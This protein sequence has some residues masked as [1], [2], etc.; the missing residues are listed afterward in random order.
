MKIADRLG[1]VPAI[2][3]CSLA[4]LLA[5]A[6]LP[7]VAQERDDDTA[8]KSKNGLAEGKLAGADVSVTYGRPKVNG[9]E[10]WGALVP[11]GQVWRAGANEAT[12]VTLSK[13]VKVGGKAVPAG[14][15]ALFLLPQKESWTFILNGKANQWGA[16]NYSEA[17]DVVRIAV[18]PLA[19]DHAEEVTFS[20]AE[21]AIWLHWGEAKAG[22]P[23]TD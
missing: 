20:V 11:Y 23:V 10:I 12:T 6:V 8:R 7:A 15:Y 14:T 16:F 18:E 2:R 5:L 21:G 9:R 17:D 19:A 13:D 22:L 4:I 1:S 3:T